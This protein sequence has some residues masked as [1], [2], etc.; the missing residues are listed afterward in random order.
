MIKVGDLRVGNYLLDGYGEIFQV[1]QIGTGLIESYGMYIYEIE[2]IKPIELTE[3]ILLKSG[4]ENIYEHTDHYFELKKEKEGF[5][6]G[7]NC[8]EYT[9]GV[10]FLHLHTLQNIFYFTTNQELKINL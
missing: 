4:F 5:I 9:H 7:I 1:K 6:V 3:E 8:F 10:H 2:E